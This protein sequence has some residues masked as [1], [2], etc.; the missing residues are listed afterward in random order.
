[1][2]FLD[3]LWISG[4]VEA[5]VTGIAVL[6]S[7]QPMSTLCLMWVFFFLLVWNLWAQSNGDEQVRASALVLK[8]DAATLGLILGNI[9][10]VASGIN[11]WYSVWWKLD[12]HYVP[13]QLFLF[14]SRNGILDLVLCCPVC[15]DPWTRKMQRWRCG[16]LGIWCY[17]VCLCVSSLRERISYGM[18]RLD[19]E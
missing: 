13:L 1:M 19:I 5:L 3:S 15:Q 9:L 14:L 12:E 17:M 4:W 11:P 7:E 10:V 18:L 2:Q 16:I 8:G 6:P